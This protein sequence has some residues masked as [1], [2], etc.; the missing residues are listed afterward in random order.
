MSKYNLQ[1][2]IGNVEIGIHKPTYFIADIAANHDGEINRAKDLIWKAKESGADCA[3]FQHFEASKIVSSVGFKQM[4]SKLSH[5]AK[6]KKSVYEVYDFYHTK[7]LWTNE[8][9]QTCKDADIEFMTTPYDINAIDEF[10]NLISA[11]KIG[12]GDITYHEALVKAS[13]TEN[14]FYWQQV[15]LN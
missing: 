11:F 2:N 14:Q 4:S 12:S 10:A 5:Q 1:F 15:L 3:K 7:K 8:L 9:I 6:W 13:Y